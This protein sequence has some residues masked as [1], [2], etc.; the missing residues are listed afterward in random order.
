MG[1]GRPAAARGGWGWPQRG[2]EAYDDVQNTPPTNIPPVFGI[3]MSKRMILINDYF[4]FLSIIRKVYPKGIYFYTFFDNG[5][6][7]IKLTK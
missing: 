5:L 4:T 1:P 2:H 7:F 6:R 3:C